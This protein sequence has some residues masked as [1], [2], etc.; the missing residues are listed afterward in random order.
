MSLQAMLCK[1]KSLRSSVQN[2]YG[3]GLRAWFNFIYYSQFR[4]NTFCIFHALLD[5]NKE[6]SIDLP[7]IIFSTPTFKELDRLRIGKN[8]PREFYCDQFHRVSQ[9]CIAL[10]E[11]ELA[12][13]HWVYRRGDFSRFLNLGEDSAEINYV[14]TL[15]QFRGS[16]I[17]TAAFKYSM[18]HLKREGIKNLFAVIH[19]ENIASLKSFNRAGFV[20][21]G[22]TVSVGPFNRKRAV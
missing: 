18:Q 14:I 21:F 15:S 20:E 22:K 9:C 7:G 8:L 12:Y 6:E 17:S 4:I 3:N 16:G 2:E 5:Q 1:V 10:V 19:N 11:G 13:I